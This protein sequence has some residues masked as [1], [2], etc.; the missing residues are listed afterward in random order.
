VRFPLRVI[1]PASFLAFALA[2]AAV[3]LTASPALAA[4][5]T[6]IG[7]NNLG[8]HCM[9]GDYSVLSLL[10]PYNTI[11]AQLVSPTGELIDDPAADGIT[12]TYRAIADPTGA[13]N[14]TSLNK[15]NFWMHVDELFGATLPVD[16]GLAGFAMPGAANTPRTMAWD[17]TQH[18]F[19][20]EGIPITPYDDQG[21]KNYYPM[22]RL[23]ARD[24][25]GALLASTDIVLP[26]SDE[27]DCSTCHSAKSGPAAKPSE[28]WSDDPDPER[29]L[30]LSILRLHDERQANDPLFG[31]AL[32][33][34]TYD[35]AG[36]ER[37]ALGGT[38]IL[39]ASCH[40][41]EALPGSGQAGVS[42]LTSAIHGLHASVTDP[43]N[44]MTLDHSGNR[45]ACYRCHPGSVTRCLRGAMGSAVASDGSLAMQCQSCHG[46]MSAVGDPARTGWLD[47]PS[48]Q[49][50]HSGTATNNAGQIRFTSAL[51]ASG[52][53]RQPADRT[54]ATNENTP[55]PGT[56][57]YR[58]STGH[59]GLKCESC[60][61]STH[62]EFPAS[63]ENDNLQS[64]A[65]QGHAGA[66]AEC[67]SCHP[68][69]PSTVSGGPHGMHPVGQ[70]WVQRHHDVVEHGGS[71]VLAQCRSCHGADDRG[72]VLSRAQADRVLSGEKVGT[73]NVWRGF[74]FGCYGCH[75]GPHSD[76]VN[77]NRA[78]VVSDATASS[79]GAPVQIALAASDADS[80]ALVLRIVSQPAHG[81]AGLAGN[82]ATYDPEPAYAGSD[83][84][85]F[86]AWDGSTDSNLGTVRMSVTAPPPSR[87]DLTAAWK[88]APSQFCTATRCRLRSGRA[89][90]RNSGD[91]I[92]AASRVR[93]YLSSD[94]TL[95]AADVLLRERSLPKVRPGKERTKNLGT[96]L[97]DA[98]T[99]AI[100]KFVIVVADATGVVAE[101]DEGNN[102]AA[103]SP[104]AAP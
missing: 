100:G 25:T 17:A 44:G 11:H 68:S 93:F 24:A 102:T 87:P 84:F 86:A 29:A 21:R 32:A 103:A 50:C 55:A 63:H 90:I 60:H 13:I 7:W 14:T 33:A 89:V 85:T 49:N 62:A 88:T 56:D 65:L 3:F 16:A 67:T 91:Q 94:A 59:G 95:D 31:P 20:A 48:C 81:T 96:I 73:K 99:S 36:L 97:L 40:L 104:I 57:L 54:F 92:A 23:E 5:Y 38:A 39:C 72:T 35:P 74:Q 34:A 70:V 42:A 51:D 101:S 9:D 58:F 75:R 98:G 64:I 45:S 26:V 12:V 30:R 41:S 19:V 76:D 82:V 8:M 46:S 15:T 47:E 2:V 78:A 52:A 66:L 6:L 83:Q 69:V 61:G 28:G 77:P 27:M 37:T 10:P 53:R 18:W 79:S 43:Q 80:N 4:R 22:M 1:S 71:A